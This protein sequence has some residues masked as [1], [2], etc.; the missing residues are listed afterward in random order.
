MRNRP[1]SN[2]CNREKHTNQGGLE[3]ATLEERLSL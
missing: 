2:N 1:A 3:T